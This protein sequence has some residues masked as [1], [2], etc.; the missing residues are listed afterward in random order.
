MSFPWFVLRQLPGQM[1]SMNE[2]LEQEREREEGCG[3]L[4]TVGAGVGSARSQGQ[5]SALLRS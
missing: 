3:P 4:D 2:M 1:Q 5:L